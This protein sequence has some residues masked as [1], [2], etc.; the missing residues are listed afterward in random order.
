VSILLVVIGPG[1][2]TVPRPHPA[3]PLSNPGIVSIPLG[4]IFAIVGTYVGELF[5]KDR[6]A[7]AKFAEI[8]VRSQTGIGMEPS[9]VEREP[10]AAAV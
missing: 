5:G 2:A 3:F 10:A 6:L 7:E 4:F 9:A 8:E 1:F